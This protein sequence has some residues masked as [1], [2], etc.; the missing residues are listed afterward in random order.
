MGKFQSAVLF[1]FLH[2]LSPRSSHL[3]S[4]VPPKVLQIQETHRVNI[5]QTRKDNASGLQTIF[6]CVRMMMCLQC[7]Y[8]IWF[9]H[10]LAFRII[11]LFEREEVCLKKDRITYLVVI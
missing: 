3:A 5:Q 8:L 10:K 4:F 7:V 6:L 1:H 11:F 2:V 9:F